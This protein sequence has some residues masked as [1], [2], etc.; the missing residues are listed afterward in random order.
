MVAKLSEHGAVDWFLSAS[1]DATLRKPAA[2]DKKG[3]TTSGEGVLI[4][5]CDGICTTFLLEAGRTWKSRVFRRLGSHSEFDGRLRAK[6]TSKYEIF[7][8]TSDCGKPF[9]AW[10]EERHR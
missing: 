4:L 7:W 8:Y 5:F 1:V 6:I 2:L 3:N 10:S 9:R